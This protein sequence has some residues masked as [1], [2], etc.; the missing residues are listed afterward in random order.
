MKMKKC[1]LQA[2]K[3]IFFKRNTSHSILNKGISAVTELLLLFLAHSHLRSLSP[4]SS[5]SPPLRTH[6]SHSPRARP[7][8]D[9][10]ASSF[11]FSN[12]P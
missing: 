9:I 6:L 10:K 12:H 3:A 2:A 11:S 8:Y 7:V 1:H 5:L 4:P